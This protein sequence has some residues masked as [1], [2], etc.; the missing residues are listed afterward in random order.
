ME[1]N[2]TKGY[3]FSSLVLFFFPYAYIQ[4]IF[5]MEMC[6]KLFAFGATAYFRD[7]WNWIDF[8][9]VCEGVISSIFQIVQAANPHQSL[10]GNAGLGI[11][12]ILRYSYRQSQEGQK[13]CVYMYISSYSK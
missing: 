3:C 7:T 6:L 10:Q 2:Q 4:V 5:F 1:N 8:V 12:K 11:L 9:V 13:M